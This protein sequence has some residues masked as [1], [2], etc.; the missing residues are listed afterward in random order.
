MLQEIYIKNFVLI[1][2]LR[3][4]FGAGLNVLTGETGAGKS[5]IMDALGLLAGERV[6]NDLIR[7]AEKRARVEAVFSMGENAEARAFLLEND[8]INED[9]DS[10]VV[11]REII[12]G[13]RSSA[14]VNGRNVSL[15]QLRDLAAIKLDMHLQHEYLSILNRSRYIEYV[16]SFITNE[17]GIISRVAACYSAWREKSARLE[18]MRENENNK[19]QQM[20]FLQYQIKEIDDARLQPGEE[21]ELTVLRNRINNAQRLLEGA[22]SIVQLIYRSEHGPSANDLIN[23]AIGICRNLREETIFAGMQQQL[24]DIFYSLEDIAKE[25]AA[26]RDSLDFEPGQL[27]AAEERLYEINRLKSKY[28]K[29]IEAIL[30]FADQSRRQMEE[31]NNSQQ[32]LGELES[33]IK[34]LAAQYTELSVNLSSMRKD[35]ARLLRDKVHRELREL[36]LP[37]I[38]FEVEVG[39]IDRW[40]PQGT[41]RVDFLFSANPGQSLRPLEKVASGGEM[42]RFVLALKAAL[43]DI[44]RVPTLI[45][46]EIDVGVGGSGLS[47]MARKLAE[48]AGTHQVI[49]VTHAPQVAAYAGVHYQIDKVVDRGTT[50]T[51]VKAL[52]HE[53]RIRELARMLAGDEYSDL[54]LQHA[55]EM[56][57]VR[58]AFGGELF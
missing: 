21:E 8:L 26:F 23:D 40:T 34:K 35:A 6:R 53:E 36:N 43:A 10:L 55:R 3:M 57:E 14:R 18:E 54:T 9:D 29:D 15:N 52:D 5:I 32:R 17:E 28:G 13:G 11:T 58:Q 37:Q 22:R 12:P 2:E 1:D 19:L 48:L 45:F 30:V 25:T 39:Q 51:V 7:D 27:E 33:D 4:E 42:S 20:D 44:Y 47:A 38:S 24:E 49:L 56:L 31:L 46:D 41:D 50:T 16:D